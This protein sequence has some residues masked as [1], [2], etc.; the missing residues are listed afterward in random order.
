MI[1]I[2]YMNNEHIKDVLSLLRKHPEGL[3]IQNISDML[4]YHRITVRN[5]L[6]NLE[7]AE[8]VKFRRIGRA[9]LYTLI[10]ERNNDNADRH[11]IVNRR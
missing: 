11:K 7:G 1:I 5:A 6:S 3:T 9:K 8:K 10:G 2:L 4:H